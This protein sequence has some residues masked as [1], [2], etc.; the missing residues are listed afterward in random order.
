MNDGA[1]FIE[2]FLKRR[3][4]RGAMPGAVWRIDSPQAA[5]ASGFVGN[6][7]A[8]PEV[9]YTQSGA[10]V[11]NFNLAT[12]ETWTKEGKKEEDRETTERGTADSI[13]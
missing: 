8:D 1:D 6:L 9:R 11:A 10:A 3:V 12:T 13:D 2:R 4:A 7:G 5:L